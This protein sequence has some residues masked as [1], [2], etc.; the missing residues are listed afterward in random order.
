MHLIAVCEA[1]ARSARGSSVAR[2]IF[3]ATI[4]RLCRSER[5]GDIA[6]LLEGD[7]GNAVAGGV[8]ETAA[9]KK[10]EQ[11]AA[12]PPAVEIIA[13]PPGPA[14]DPGPGP[15]LWAAVCRAAAATPNGQA[16]VEHLAFRSFDG[17]Q[18]RLAVTARDEGL[19]RWLATQGPAVAELVN[20]AAAQ[21]VQVVVEAPAGLP[22]SPASK[23]KA[24][25]ELPLVRSTM[26]IFDATVV[27]V[28]DERAPEGGA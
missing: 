15:A 18:L 19:A 3:D 2:A 20:R 11:L 6:A 28:H 27:G 4:V 8:A 7:G 14:A 1:A 25:E 17:R 16:L 23:F 9:P 24:A 13:V 26:A 12:P 10:K 21:R 22:S 5:F